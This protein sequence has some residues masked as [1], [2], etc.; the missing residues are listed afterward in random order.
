M[1]CTP[2]V[3]I[4]H[5]LNINLKN[6][7]SPINIQNLAAIIA[8]QVKGVEAGLPVGTKARSQASNVR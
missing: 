4:N 8:S 1:K 3:H 2:R 7:L 6:I 5:C